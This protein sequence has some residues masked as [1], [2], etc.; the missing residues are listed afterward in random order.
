MQEDARNEKEKGTRA[1]EANDIVKENCVMRAG[2]WSGGMLRLVRRNQL[3]AFAVLTPVLRLQ[4]MYDVHTSAYMR[5]RLLV[6][7]HASRQPS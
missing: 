3:S 7:A 4:E 1:A 6:R 2:R 5:L